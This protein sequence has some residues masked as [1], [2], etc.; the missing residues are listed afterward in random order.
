MDLKKFKELAR[1][2]NSLQG[3]ATFETATVLEL[4]A[5]PQAQPALT[6]AQQMA[7]INVAHQ[8]LLWN[9]AQDEPLVTGCDEYAVALKVLELERLALAPLQCAE[10]DERADTQ[11]AFETYFCMT[12]SDEGTESTE[13]Y[14]ACKATASDAWHEA[15]RRAIAAAQPVAA[16]G[17]VVAYLVDWAD[18]GEGIGQ[19]CFYG[20]SAKQHMESAISYAKNVRN[21]PAKVTPLSPP[22]PVA[23]PAVAEGWKLVPVEPTEAMMDA[24]EACSDDWPRT[25]WSKAFAAM[26]A[27]V[28]S[29]P[30]GGA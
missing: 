8:F 7:D 23:A 19:S 14:E 27:A 18:I 25:T 30:I 16:Q 26:L 9:R 11:H 6:D 4:I 10:P 12:L 24:A 13:L 15:T 3:S 5:A 17:V 1:V 22:A 28:P 29:A 21:R 2:A 20:E